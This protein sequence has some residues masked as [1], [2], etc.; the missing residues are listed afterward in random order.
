M[1][2]SKR[3]AQQNVRTVKLH[4]R[5]ETKQGAISAF[6]SMDQGNDKNLIEI[7]VIDPVAEVHYLLQA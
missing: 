4:L 7:G 5:P 6:S 3:S 2:Y 1:N